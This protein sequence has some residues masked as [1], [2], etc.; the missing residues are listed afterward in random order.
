MAIQSNI[1]ARQYEY[2]YSVRNKDD[3]FYSLLHAGHDFTDFIV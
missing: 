2:D 1:W 3:Y